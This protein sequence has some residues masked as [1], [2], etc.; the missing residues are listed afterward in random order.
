MSLNSIGFVVKSYE[1]EEISYNSVKFIFKGILKNILD[2]NFRDSVK[3]LGEKYKFI[4]TEYDI[5]KMWPNNAFL[6]QSALEIYVSFIY[7]NENVN[8]TDC[9]K[10]NTREFSKENNVTVQKD[11]FELLDMR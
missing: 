6:N 11:R 8:M 9:I 4:F 7:K 5:K 2:L 10:D 3:S 1:A